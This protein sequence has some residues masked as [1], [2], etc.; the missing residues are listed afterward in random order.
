[1]HQTVGNALRALTTM[2]PPAGIT[3][4]AQLVDTALANAMYATRAAFHGALN[5]SPGALVFIA[6]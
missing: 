5:T 3:E 6:T 2:N 4:A 1:M